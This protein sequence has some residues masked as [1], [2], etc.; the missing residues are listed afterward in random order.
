MKKVLLAILITLFWVSSAYSGPWDGWSSGGIETAKDCNVAAYYPLGTLCQDTDDGK[1]YKGTGSGVTEIAAGSSGD[2]TAATTDITWGDGTGP[3]VFT[4]SVTGT[5]PT[6]TA[7]ASK[8]D[9][10]ASSLAMTG[11]LG[12]TGAGKLT[13]GWFID[14]ES[15]NMPTVNGTA[16][17]STFMPIGWIS[18]AGTNNVLTYTGNYSLGLTLSNNTAVTLPTSGTL[19]TT[20]YKPA[21]LSIASQAAGD[22]LYFDGTNWVRL[23]ADA[24]KY[25]KSGA[26]AVSWDTP[27]GGGTVDI[28]GTPANH[29]WTS[30]TDDNTV[31]GTAITSSKPVCSDA[32]GDPAVC[33][34][35]EG[36]W[37]VAGS[38]QAADAD[39]TAIAALSC[40][41][42]QIIKR[43]GAGAWVCAADAND[44]GT[45]ALDDVTD[46]DAA[47][48]FTLLD[49]NASAL[50]IGSTGAADIL[51]II[52][53]DASEGIT[54]SKYLTV[55]GALTA[56]LTGTATGLAGTPNITVGTVNAGAGGMTVDADGDVTAKSVTITKASGS[57]GDMGLYESN[58]TDTHAAGFRG[59]DSISGDGAYRIKFPDARASSANMVLAVTNGSESG[60]GT[61]ASPYIQTGSWIDLDNYMLTTKISTVT[62]GK[63][64]L[65]NS[66]GNI[67]CTTDAPG[68]SGDVTDVGDCSSGACLDGSSDGGTYIRL[69]DGTS[70]Y[71][72]I[73][74]GV[75]TLT[76]APSNA[77]AENLTMTFGDNDNTVALGSGT[78]ATVSV[79]GNA[80]GLTASTSNTI[81]VGTIELGHA[82]DTTISRVSAGVIAVEGV[83][84]APLANPQFTGVVDIPV[85]ATT[86][87]EGEITIDTT[88]DQLRYYGGAQ[89]VIPSAQFFSFAIPAPAEA[90]DI[91]VLKAPYGMTI[92]GISCIVQG[93]T[94]VTG[95]LQEC[96]TDG[97]SCANLDS[98]ITCDADGAADDGTLTDNTIASGAWL[99]WKTTSVSGTPTFLTVTVK[100]N[101][102]AD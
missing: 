97:T 53:T 27:V 74:A 12:A 17:D 10:G 84:V 60:S 44:G 24:G 40:T 45:P 102:V 78:G 36:V 50:S 30:W 20:T 35:T 28:S 82:S 34:G 71:S 67:V 79:N 29:Y 62:D 1:L 8:F 88:T 49:N 70:A 73:T 43:N 22:V 83:T 81:G 90:D 59:P 89:K 77:D 54:M 99:R 46:P 86:D 92:T 95:Q 76:F 98:D 65:G 2:V 41:E 7:T 32:S 37:Q 94:S 68:G 55:T 51:K 26:S 57:A 9:F 56:T 11:S 47:K 75:R 5:D 101:V 18:R 61:A 85:N 13:K 39:L 69:Y 16:I 14:I 23:A 4:F 38:Y 33:A 3:S 42:N 93:T 21:D 91:N 100:Y 96:G 63:Y 80:G 48:T 64:C 15:T 66:S 19:A 52:T 31:K 87:A 58:S 6:I 25:L 72:G